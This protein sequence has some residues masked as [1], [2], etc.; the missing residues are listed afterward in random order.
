[1]K[2]KIGKNTR[3]NYNDCLSRSLRDRT[4]A[5]GQQQFHLRIPMLRKYHNFMAMYVTELGILIAF[6]NQ[7]PLKKKRKKHLIFI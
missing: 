7:A 1:M 3:P 5:K 4:A 2:K 6:V